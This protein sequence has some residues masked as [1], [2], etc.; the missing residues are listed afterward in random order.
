MG[1]SSEKDRVER[2]GG[3]QDRRIDGDD[4]RGSGRVETES[5]S[6]RQ[7]KERRKS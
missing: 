7:E 3:T 6:R 2:R 4:R 1:D 5:E